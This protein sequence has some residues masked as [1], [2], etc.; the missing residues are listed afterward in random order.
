MSHQ[1]VLSD[2]IKYTP[3][4][5]LTIDGAD[6]AEKIAKP[7]GTPVYAYSIPGISSAVRHI[8]EAYGRHHTNVAIR[9]SMKANSNFTVVKAIL[10]EGVGV[11]C[12]SA[13][14]VFKALTCGCKPE[15]IVFA[16]AG[17]SAGEL[18][19]AVQQGVGWFNVENEVELEILEKIC[20]DLDKS[21]RAALRLNPDVEANTITAIATGHGGA[22][23]GMPT[24]V[25]TRLLAN[26]DK[27]PHLS[28][29]GI[30]LHIGSQLGD[31]VQSKAAIR[32]AIE[33]AKVFKSVTTINIG[34]GMPVSYD[35]A[36]EPAIEEFA[37][38]LS[39]LLVDFHVVLEPG[40]SVVGP[41]GVLVTQVLYS[42]EQGNQRVLIVDASMTDLMRPALY[43]AKHQ[44][45]PVTIPAATTKNSSNEDV[46]AKFEMGKFTIVGPVCESTDVLCRDV[47]L[48]LEAA[49][50]GALLA[51]MTAGAYGASMASNYNAR[52]LAPQVVVEAGG[53]VRCSTKR[54]TFE[55]L[56]RDELDRD[57]V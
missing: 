2:H 32:K 27:Y 28:M 10:A 53:S 44:A 36:E 49:K 19:Y 17:K 4:G 40:R 8:K 9:Y 16:G 51:L 15:D 35:N 23:F 34:G 6:V 56:I 14:E 3:G 29:D 26:S 7:F 39:P 38:E 52:P 45:L 5:R 25:V 21:V 22:K 31:T 12:V 57:D 24:D 50:P 47:E 42:K 11:D 13:G 41:S 20:V 37:K 54:Q 48:P 46:D 55:D 43:D 30:H 1:S 33:L 18:Q